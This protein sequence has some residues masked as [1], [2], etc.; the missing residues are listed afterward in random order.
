MATRRKLLQLTGGTM[1]AGLFGRLPLSRAAA[2]ENPPVSVPA[3]RRGAD[4]AITAPRLADARHA[5][6]IG[7]RVEPAEHGQRV[8]VVE[9]LLEGRMFPGVARFVP[10]GGGGPVSVDCQVRLE[11]SERLV[12][13]ARLADG[14]TCR[15][16]RDVAVSSG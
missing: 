13:V 8:E 2:S 7:I 15:A 5:I 10:V 9:L 12:V 3:A 11:Q 1:A 14:T 4:I 16:S 6:P